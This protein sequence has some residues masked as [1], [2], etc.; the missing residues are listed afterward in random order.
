MTHQNY[1]L[2]T[3]SMRIHAPIKSM[4]EQIRRTLRDDIALNSFVATTNDGRKKRAEEL[5]ARLTS[6]AGMSY[7]L[8]CL[9]VV[10]KEE[11]QIVARH[12]LK[13]RPQKAI[14]MNH[15]LR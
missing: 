2:K 5:L 9:S 4:I 7:V 13:L 6:L 11:T 3:T 8:G 12:W 14:K 10:M 15:L 1:R